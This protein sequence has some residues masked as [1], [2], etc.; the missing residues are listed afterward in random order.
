MATPYKKNIVTPIGTMS[1]PWLTQGNPDIRFGAPGKYKVNLII[2]GPEAE[3]FKAKVD[4]I[5]AEALAHL[6]KDNPKL[7]DLVVP[8]DL[9]KDEN[10]VEIP[11]TY[12]VKPKANAAF[13]NADGTE[14][15]NKLVRVDADKKPI[16]EDV[17]VWSGSK[18]KVAISVGAIDSGVYKGL[19]FRIS[20]I[21][22]TELVEG[23][24]GGAS[25]M[26]EKEDGYSA[27]EVVKED[28]RVEETTDAD[29]VHF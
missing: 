2:T 6:Q 24:A 1:Y 11:G 12:V 13:R 27:P 7:Q 10:G 23:G 28:T 26:F 20:A 22:I 29:P 8:L 16:A 3:E 15:P 9:H 18:G 14:T 4:E 5:K 21:Q 19:V 25:S 17:A